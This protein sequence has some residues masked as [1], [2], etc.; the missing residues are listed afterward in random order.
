MGTKTDYSEEIKNLLLNFY[1]PVASKEEATENTV[2]KTLEEVHE[3]VIRVLPG[4]WIYTDDVFNAL[5]ELGFKYFHDQ[6][7]EGVTELFYYLEAK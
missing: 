4:R 7:D 5:D 2:K 3:E 1:S 6:D